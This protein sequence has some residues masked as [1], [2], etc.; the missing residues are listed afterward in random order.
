MVDVTTAKLSS[1]HFHGWQLGLKTGLYYLRTKAEIDL[2]QG[3]GG[4]GWGVLGFLC[5]VCFRKVGFPPRLS[6]F[7]L[8]VSGAGGE[9]GAAVLGVFFFWGG[10]GVGGLGGFGMGFRRFSRKI[11]IPGKNGH[12]RY[13]QKNG[14]HTQTGTI[15]SELRNSAAGAFNLKDESLGGLRPA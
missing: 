12:G 9:R 7:R 10:G 11:R 2:E 4:E 14:N 15:T 1:M 5:P 3:G 8:K 6:S 13:P